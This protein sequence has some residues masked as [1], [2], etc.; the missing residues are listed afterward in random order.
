M[1]E[2]IGAFLIGAIVGVALMKTY[3]DDIID[4]LHKLYSEALRERRVEKRHDHT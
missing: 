2:Y 3:Y 1:K 4:G